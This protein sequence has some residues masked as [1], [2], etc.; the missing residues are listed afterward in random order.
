MLRLCAHFSNVR[1]TTVNTKIQLFSGGRN[2]EIL[3]FLQKPLEE[4]YEEAMYQ[5]G[6]AYNGNKVLESCTDFSFV[7]VCC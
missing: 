5:I 3:N 4:G 6:L 7:G 1:L 2:R